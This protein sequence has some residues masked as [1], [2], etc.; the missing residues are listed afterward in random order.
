MNLLLRAFVIVAFTAHCC[1]AKDN[2]VL[3]NGFLARTISIEHGVLRT[4]Q[5]I[6]K[7]TGAPVNPEASPEFR[8]RLSG[9]EV[10]SPPTLLTAADFRVVTAAPFEHSA[11]TGLRVALTNVDRGIGVEVTYELGKNDFFMRKRLTISSAK[12]VVL[13]RID[14]EALRIQD[15]RQP[16]AMREITSRA[17][18]R[19]NPGLGQPLYTTKSGTFW[20]IEFPAADNQVKDGALSTGY[21]WGRTLQP[22][23]SYSTYA[24]VLGVADDPR[25]VEDAFFDYIDSVRA[26]PLRL[27]VQYNSWFD[28]GS[29][30]DEPKFAASVATIHQ[31]LVVARGNPPF[32]GYVIDDGWE[33]ATTNWSDKVWKENEKFAPNFAA[34]FQTVTNAKSRLGLWLSPGCLFGAR[35]EIALLRAQEF[36]ALS[37]SMS[38]AGP[39]YMQALEDRLAELTRSGVNFFKLDGLFGHLNVRDFDLNCRQYGIAAMPDLAGLSPDDVRLNDSKY[40]EAKIYYLAAGTER[41]MRIFQRLGKIDPNIHIVIS[42]GAYL[43]PWWLMYVDDVW[44]INAGDAA[45][46]TDRSAQLTY[47]DG[48]YYDIWQVKHIQFPMCSVFNHEPKKVSTGE[49]P[50][51]FRNYLFMSLSRGTGFIELYLKPSVLQHADWD[52]LSEGL[53]WAREMFPTFRRV[54]MHGGDPQTGQVYGFTAWNPTRGY[55]SIHN[56]SDQPQTYRLALNRE[57]GMYPETRQYDLKPGLKDSTAG[58]PATCKFGD[59][60]TVK[61]APREIRVI[62]FISK[63]ISTADGRP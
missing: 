32:D 24:A 60:L 18:G 51:E 28:F 11:H 19:W 55:V 13:E 1:A 8:L 17:A 25:F 4:T 15:A 39:R 26:R 38:M 37:N 61:L 33:N 42:N 30:V 5:I 2:Y 27:R 56:P 44:M 46:G 52:V 54:R 35:P 14:I 21:L 12:P 47:R 63:T 6:N 62:D 23:E 49:S 40:D 9:T 57:T 58:L 43:S 22:G 34:A 48:R 16:Y 59:T 29:R 50:E 3:E 31:E 45:S 10:S 53:H 7:R 36:E 20:G 41:L